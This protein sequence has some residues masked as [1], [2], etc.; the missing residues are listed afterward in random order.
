MRMNPLQYYIVPLS[1]ILGDIFVLTLL[2]LGPTNANVASFN[3]QP[4]PLSRSASQ[5]KLTTRPTAEAHEI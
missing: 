2:L 1:P 5:K 4:L 3:S